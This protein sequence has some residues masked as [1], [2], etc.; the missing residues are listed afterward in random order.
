MQIGIKVGDIMTR[1]F[2]SVSPDLPVAQCAKEMMVKH[3]GS[4]IIKE[5]QNLKGILT[6]GDVV[7]AIGFK[8]NLSKVRAKDVM[9]RQIFTISPSED[10]YVALNK[11]KN[12]KVRW[13][14]VTVKGRVIGLLTIKDILRVEPSLFEIAREFTP[15]KEEEEKLKS[16][17][18]RKKRSALASGEVWA[19]EGLCDECETY[20]LL[21]NAGGK[22]LCEECKNEQEKD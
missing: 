14:P 7:K 1:S 10:I 20:E 21:Y 13:L 5:G 12:K 9:T 17:G 11:M 18:L 15:I 22:M 19:S 2:I 8:K 16:V 3:V 4:L 6:E